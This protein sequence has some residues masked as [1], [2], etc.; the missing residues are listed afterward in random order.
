MDFSHFYSLEEKGL[1]NAVCVDFVEDFDEWEVTRGERIL[2]EYALCYPCMGRKYY[3]I[4]I[5][6]RVCP[7]VVSGKIID[8]LT[9]NNI[10]GWKATSV[11]I[12]GKEDLRYYVLM[13]TGRC[14]PV[15]YAKSER[16]IQKSPGGIDCPYIRGLYFEPESWD[17]TDI[18]VA[19]N[20]SWIFC[21]GKVKKVIERIKA[22]NISFESCTDITIDA[23]A[24]P[25]DILSCLMEKEDRWSELVRT[26]KNEAKKTNGFS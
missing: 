11:R 16:I 22:T 21:T 10:T 3:D 8:A 5:P 1:L 26:I 15:D 23:F 20:V 25:K 14:G 2:P 19:D 17:G 9:E 7:F 12:A 4:I 13:I 6:S 24:C 18:F